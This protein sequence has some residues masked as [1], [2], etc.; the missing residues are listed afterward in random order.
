MMMTLRTRLLVGYG[1]LVGLLVATA[2]VSALG[3]Q[4]FGFALDRV[5]SENVPSVRDAMDMTEALERQNA[6]TFAV[7]L[8]DRTAGKALEAADDSF[9]AALARAQEH[10][11]AEGEAALV[12]AL[13]A[14][15]LDLRAARGRLIASSPATPLA[16]Y[17]REVRQHSDV[18]KRGV[19]KL[20]GAN[21]DAM[22]DADRK[23]REEA[24]GF[25]L[26]LASLVVVALLSLGFLSRAL[27]RTILSRLTE[28]KEL[29]DAIAAGDRARRFR[30]RRDD[31]LGLL[32]RHLNAAL[33][34]TDALQA[35]MEGRFNQQAQLLLG[36]LALRR[37]PAA[38][39]GLDG[40]AIASTLPS[41][42]E[43]RVAALRERIRAER[44]G[45]DP[46][47]ERVVRRL[48]VEGGPGVTLELLV[49]NRQRAVGWLVSLDRPAKAK[50]VEEASATE[51]AGGGARPDAPAE[52][53]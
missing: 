6:A 28:L 48:E 52:A 3:L 41:R 50:A 12:A 33:D 16:A 24:L 40:D 35:Q 14:E 44:K 31:E 10:A 17:E 22:H 39:V 30:A 9:D 36:L 4:R 53:S 29:G 1:Y 38:V 21:L 26:G 19:L 20:L 23:A 32:A 42:D 43:A 25:A 7:L 47:V 27:Q 2:G 5:L 51:P 46:R 49:A 8:G 13:R 11:F 18:V 37:D 45:A 15:S 34:S